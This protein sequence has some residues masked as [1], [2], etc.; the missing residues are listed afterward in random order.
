MRCRNSDCQ[1]AP[2]CAIRRADLGTKNQIVPTD[3]KPPA[4][5]PRREPWKDPIQFTVRPSDGRGWI[6]ALSIRGRLEN[7]H[8]RQLMTHADD[9]MDMS[10]LL[11]TWDTPG[12]CTGAGVTLDAL[13]AMCK[14]RMPV[15]SWVRQGLSAA[16]LPIASCE[17]AFSHPCAELG[18][19]GI[20]RGVCDGRNPR[21]MVNRQS[22]HKLDGLDPLPLLDLT[23][24]RNGDAM[25]IQRDIDKIYEVALGQLATYTGTNADRLRR[26]MD[27]RVLTSR[28]ARRIGLIDKI[29][30]EHEAYDHLTTLMKGK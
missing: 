20:V 9:I 15:V 14:T 24:C 17:A 10:G 27:G 4:P 2:T 3:A 5:P 1:F 23:F 19:F 29:G 18:G 8:Q 12:G 13:I 22:P 21:T 11:I 30:F 7:T 26:Y 28:Q 16:T 6:G 25:A